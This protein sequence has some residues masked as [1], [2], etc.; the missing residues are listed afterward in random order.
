[1]TSLNGRLLAFSSADRALRATI[2]RRALLGRLGA[3]AGMVAA[4]A[5]LGA[6]LP[7]PV[8]AQDPP[9]T[10]K[11]PKD[12]SGS[13]PVGGTRGPTRSRSPSRVY[14]DGDEEATPGGLPGAAPSS[15]EPSPGGL[16]GQRPPSSS[17][18]GP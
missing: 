5:S 3:A 2:S 15:P 9:G 1:M 16:P 12:S 4:A 6:A 14:R 7:E 10:K 17:R 8:W 18:P 11:V 13:A